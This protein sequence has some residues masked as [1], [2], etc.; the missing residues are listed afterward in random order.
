MAG[1]LLQ[2]CQYACTAPCRA[3]G[4]CC[5]VSCRACDACCGGI[6]QFIC[7]PDRA[8]PV[9]LT[10]TLAMNGVTGAIAV[11][12]AAMHIHND[13]AKSLHVWLLVEALVF[14]LFF[15]VFAARIHYVYN[16]PDT[17]A[18]R[19]R[20]AR[21]IDRAA[22]ICWWE[23]VV[24]VF[25]F[26]WPAAVAWSITGLTWA[27][28]SA[29]VRHHGAPGHCSRALIHF[30]RVSAVVT[31]VFLLTCAAVAA[32][33]C[34]C[35]SLISAF[36]TP[37]EEN[38]SYDQNY[39]QGAPATLPNAA[40]APQQ[41]FLSSLLHPQ[42]RFQQQYTPQYEPLAGDQPPPTQQFDPRGLPPPS[43]LEPS[44]PPAPGGSTSPSVPPLKLPKN[45]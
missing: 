33:G 39:P 36:Q 35:Q 29:E 3:C 2:G 45:M 11:A 8:S 25:A 5:T 41:S 31:L 21:S 44:A 40:E 42:R 38:A 26:A 30:S 23:P 1:Y 28:H 37:D 20:P 12:V 10:Y 34:C 13:C 18:Q 24:A 22:Q 14:N 4:E 43:G 17:L 7:P 9:F 32:F 19:R 15:I 16:Q 6:A 27:A